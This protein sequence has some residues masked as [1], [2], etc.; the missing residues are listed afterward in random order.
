VEALHDE[1]GL[2]PKAFPA[3]QRHQGLDPGAVG[4]HG[5]VQIV[6][7]GGLQV[8]FGSGGGAAMADVEPEH[9]PREPVVME[10]GIRQALAS[11]HTAYTI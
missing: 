1:V 5:H 4:H 10:Q 8:A 9:A 6:L 2:A 3:G 7:P 11:V